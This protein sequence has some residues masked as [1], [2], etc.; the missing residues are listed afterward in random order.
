M[1][2]NPFTI[3]EP[4]RDMLDVRML[5]RED[6]VASD[7]ETQRVLGMEEIVVLD[8]EHGHRCIVVSTPS[9]RTEKA[10]AA[11][12]DRPGLT[13]TIR[14]ADCQNFIVFDPIKKVL[15]LIHAGWRGV[16]CEAIAQAFLCMQ[17]E[18]RVLPRD[19]LVGA[20]P[21]LCRT[22]AEF[23][24]PGKEVPELVSYAQG[25]CI[26]LNGAADDQLF[27]LGV[28][29]DRFERIDDCTLC[30]PEKYWTYRGGKDEVV[31]NGKRNVLAATLCKQK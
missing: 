3:F 24:D 1:I 28:T 8:Q 23:T 6:D 13:L 27:S 5:K 20:G 12:T 19:V 17:S 4:Y 2:K 25:R 30:N 31:K 18:W 11:A 22:C 26:D 14:F 9:S 16:Q 15:C 29:R 21:S 7:E 10:D